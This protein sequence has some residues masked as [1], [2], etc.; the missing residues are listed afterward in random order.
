MT[1]LLIVISSLLL[2]GLMF[3]FIKT[4]PMRRLKGGYNP[5]TPDGSEQDKD[6]GKACQRKSGQRQ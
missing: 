3:A 5:G 6:E 4:S 2:A 1:L